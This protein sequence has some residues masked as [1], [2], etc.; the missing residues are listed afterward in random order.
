MTKRLTLLLATATL[1]LATALAG[2]TPAAEAHDGG[3]GGG[4]EVIRTGNCSGRADWKLKAKARDG[5]FEVEYEVDSNRVGQTWHYTLR[6]NGTVRA[7]GNRV[8]R[9]PSGSF[10]VERRM[11][12][13]AGRDSFV[14]TAR[15]LR[16]GQTCSGTL[17]V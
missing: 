14:G 11:P 8:T 2:W 16:T 15:N 6:Q 5:G 9:G 12:N 7:Q 1:L 13:T 3:G 17:T 10:S 4:D